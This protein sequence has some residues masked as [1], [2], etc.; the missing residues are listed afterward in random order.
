MIY[1]ENGTSKVSVGLEVIFTDLNDFEV[2][3]CAIGPNIAMITW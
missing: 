2:Q 1:L 3:K